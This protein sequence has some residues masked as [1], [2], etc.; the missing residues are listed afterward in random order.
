MNSGAGGGKRHGGAA[1]GVWGLLARDHHGA[2][3][4]A[5][6]AALADAAANGILAVADK[7]V[8]AEAAEAT[9]VVERDGSSV[10]LT[11]R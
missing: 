10:F 6:S 11:D 9:R 2:R 3:V 8:A 5:V 7:V 1:A 4:A